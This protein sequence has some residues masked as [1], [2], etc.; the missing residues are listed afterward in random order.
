MTTDLFDR[1]KVPSWCT[2]TENRKSGRIRTAL[3][4]TVALLPTAL[5]AMDAERLRPNIVFFMV[6]DLGRERLRAYG[7][8]TYATPNIDRLAA[9]G[10]SFDICYATPMCSPTRVMLMSGKYNFRNYDAWGTYPF[11]SEQTIAKTLADAG[12]TTAVT[13]KWHLGGWERPPFGPTR[14][15]FHFYA[16]YNYPEQL[17]EDFTATGNFFW[18]TNLWL[19]TSDSAPERLRLGTTFS[20]A[21]F[22]DFAVRFIED[23]A[24]RKDPFFLYYPEILVHRPF[25]PTDRDGETGEAHRGRRGDATHFPDMLRYTDDIVGAL[26]AALERSGQAKNTLFIFTSDN[27]TDNVAEAL[28]MM[29]RWRGRDTPGGKY[30]PT[31]LGINVPFIAWWPGTIEAGGRYSGPVDF[32]DFHTTFSRLAGVEPPEGLDGHDLTPVLTGQGRSAR[33][34]AYS[35]GV[36]EFSSRKYRTPQDFPDDILHALRDERWKY[37]SDGRLYDLECDP[38][39]TK[40]VPTGA[41]SPVRDRFAE[42]LESLRSSEPRLW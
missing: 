12:Y 22:R 30:L 32:T 17:R 26:V 5:P 36:F 29:A 27:G 20:S 24:G 35:W 8:E 25:V 34:Y 38:F 33:A 37:F 42:A 7:G 19:G 41:Y 13:G 10:M 18:N 9:E 40:P 4:L 39:E 2:I 28:G 16:T 21:Y 15:G 11:A 6:D 1:L 3:A 31:E 14:A 23:Q